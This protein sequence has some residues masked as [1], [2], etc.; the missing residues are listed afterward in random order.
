MI[1]DA[2]GQQD[3]DYLPLGASGP[4][5]F[6]IQMIP[7]RY[8]VGLES[9]LPVGHGLLKRREQDVLPTGVVTLGSLV[10]AAAAA[11]IEATFNANVR[12]AVFNV[13]IADPRKMALDLKSSNGSYAWANLT[14]QTQSPTLLYT[15][16]QV[17]DEGT[18][19]G[20]TTSG[21]GTVGGPSL[22]EFCVPCPLP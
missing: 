16:C 17:A 2:S 5:A 3:I 7:G 15:G 14:R 6:N 12:R 19:E 13:V 21:F 4:A 10:V 9:Y 11:P 1:R 20:P 18:T 22:G 8:E